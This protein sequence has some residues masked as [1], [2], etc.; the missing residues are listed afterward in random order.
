MDNLTQKYLLYKQFV[1][2]ACDDCSVAPLTNYINNPI[3]QELI[4]EDKYD[5]NAS[6]KRIYLDLWASPEYLNEA[7]KLERNDSRINLG[8]VLK[9]T[10]KKKLRPRIWAHSIGEYLYILTRS[11]LTLRHKT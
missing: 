9:D 1:A 6:D 3:Y 10:A 2:W 8:I 4:D 5:G 11:G 7:E